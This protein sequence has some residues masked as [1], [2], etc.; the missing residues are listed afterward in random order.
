MSENNTNTELLAAINPALPSE[1]EETRND[2]RS[3]PQSPTVLDSVTV[4]LGTQETNEPNTIATSST[5]SIILPTPNT[6]QF[7]DEQFPTNWTPTISFPPAPTIFSLD[8]R[9]PAL[10]FALLE[11]LSPS[12]FPPPRPTPAP[13]NLQYAFAPYYNPVDMERWLKE[14]ATRESRDEMIKQDRHKDPPAPY[15]PEQE[16]IMIGAAKDE[17]IAIARKDS[18]HSPDQDIFEE[19]FGYDSEE[20]GFGNEDIDEEDA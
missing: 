14:K 8:L 12:K 6:Q 17:S 9:T 11:S 16:R 4:V 3:T 13:P 10:I 19:F 2:E 7:R 18:V 5:T 1:S 20:G 15:C